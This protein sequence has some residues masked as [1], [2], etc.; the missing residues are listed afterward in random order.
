MAELADA[1]ASGASDSNIMRVQLSPSAQ[2]MIFQ[3][4]GYLSA[5]AVTLSFVPYAKDIFLGKTKPERASWFI[6]SVLNFIF[7]FSLLSKGINYSLFLPGI[8]ALG[9]LFIFLI[10][11]PYGIGGF[12]KRDVIGLIAAGTGL[13]LW[14]ITQEALFALLIAIF[15]DCVGIFLTVVKSYESPTTE[16]MSTWVLGFL[17]GLFALF[18]IG[19][20][21]IVYIIFPLYICIAH[22]SV[23][24][25]IK[26]GKKK[27]Q[28]KNHSN[29]QLNV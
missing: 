18:A 23:I 8:Q 1:L 4:F 5:I 19:S 13:L 27:L 29:I 20:F 3:I 2:N 25:A 11:I 12:L 24:F 10:A 9:D 21:K 17:A 14:Y 16:T 26:L 22:A 28:L 7:F 15:I 6:W